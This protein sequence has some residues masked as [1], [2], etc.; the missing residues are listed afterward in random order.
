[1]IYDSN[2]LN[3]K[4]H[5]DEI[6]ETVKG[7]PV[8]FLSLEI[9]VEPEG[10]DTVYSYRIAT[11]V[12]GIDEASKADFFDDLNGRGDTME[13]N[14]EKRC[15]LGDPY[16]SCN[17]NDQSHEREAASPPWCDREFPA[18]EHAEAGELAARIADT[19]RYYGK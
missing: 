9:L 13:R 4:I 3:I 12:A 11:P 14:D 16:C 1:M 6:V 17:G 19:K 5:T 10:G 8:G 18:M 7:K 2:K 15:S